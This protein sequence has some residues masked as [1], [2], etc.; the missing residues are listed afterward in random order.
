MIKTAAFKKHGCVCLMLVPSYAGIR[1]RVATVTCRE[2]L[3]SFK[4]GP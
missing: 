1:I 3:A 4:D 2:G